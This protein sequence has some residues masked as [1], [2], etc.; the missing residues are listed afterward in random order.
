MSEMSEFNA[1]Y[2]KIVLEI[3]FQVKKDRSIKY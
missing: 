1:Q 3:L 2:Q